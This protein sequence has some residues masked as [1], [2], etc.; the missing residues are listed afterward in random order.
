MKKATKKRKGKLVVLLIDDDANF[1]DLIKTKLE[2]NKLVVIEAKDG[3]DSLAK[4]RAVMP[5]LI[6]LDLEM[7]EMNGIEVFG[8]L[9][10]DPVL[11]DTKVVFLTTHDD[12]RKMDWVD[13][14]FGDLI[15]DVPYIRKSETLDIVLEKIREAL[16]NS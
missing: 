14:E 1:R 16:K 8:R 12:P 3:K 6:L 4:V 9:R 11:R 15:K 5:D 7:P 2:A 13:V 10:E